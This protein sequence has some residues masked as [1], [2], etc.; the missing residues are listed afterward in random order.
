MVYVIFI[1]YSVLTL[2]S[3]YLF[4]VGGGNPT[5]AQLMEV[6]KTMYKTTM[7]SFRRFVHQLA[8]LWRPLSL[9]FLCFRYATLYSKLNTCVTV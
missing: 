4:L 5:A 9:W 7:M 2:A 6:M 3:L 8:S 1:G